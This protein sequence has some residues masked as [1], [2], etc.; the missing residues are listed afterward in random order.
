MKRPERCAPET[1]RCA[2]LERSGCNERRFELFRQ[3][4]RYFRA[5]RLK[6]SDNEAWIRY[7]RSRGMQIGEKCRILDRQEPGEPFLIR[8]GNHVTIT[9]GCRLVTHDGGI[10]IYR[11]IDPVVNRFGPIDIR[12]NCFI[13]LN[14]IILPGVTIGPNSIVAAGSVVT[15][16]VPPGTIS[17]GV[18]A[19]PIV[20]AEEYLDRIRAESIPV[21]ESE[22][23]RINA[24][25]DQTEVMRETLLQS[26]SWEEWDRN[27]RNTD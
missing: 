13:G 5:L 18:P 20:S 17:G 22:R 1:E 21:S 10:W 8:I 25:E 24:G 3:L 2:G 15:K 9:S 23:A 27:R 19:R 12:D 6:T 4:F 26:F 7:L 14:S 16:D 11:E